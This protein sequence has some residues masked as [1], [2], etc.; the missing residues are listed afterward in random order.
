MES[1]TYLH[2][3]ELVQ[4]E[5]VACEGYFPQRLDVSQDVQEMVQVRDGKPV[6]SALQETE[7]AAVHYQ[8]V[9]Y[10][11]EVVAGYV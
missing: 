3:V 1:A 4:R 8:E 10:V 5:L 2:S 9:V 11:W 6:V 7:P